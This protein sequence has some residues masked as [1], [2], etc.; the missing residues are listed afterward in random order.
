M[1][2]YRLLL[3]VTIVLFLL[4]NTSQLWDDMFGAWAFPAFIFLLVV[5]GL[6]LICLLYQLFLT[7]KE[8]FKNKPRVYLTGIMILLLLAMYVNPTGIINFDSFEGPDLLTARRVGVANCH[9]V[10]KL[11]K[12]HSFYLRETCFG[13]EKFSGRYTVDNDTIRFDS[14]VTSRG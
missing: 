14:G 7:I 2:K 6:L 11:K 9:T 5:Y 12:D 13:V 10:L 8:K 4:V 3:I 1:R